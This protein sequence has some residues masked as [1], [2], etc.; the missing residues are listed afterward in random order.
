MNS[1]IFKICLVTALVLV[2]AQTFAQMQATISGTVRTPVGDGVSNV[3]LVLSD[4][5]GNQIASTTTGADGIYSFAGV[6]ESFQYSITLNKADAPLNGVSTFDQVLMI[7][8]ILGIQAISSPYYLIGADINGSQTLTT[9]DAVLV[10]RLILGLNDQ[11]PGAS[12]RFLRADYNFITPSNP[13]AEANSLTNTF[14]LNGNLSG[15]DF[16]GVKIG[17]IND[18]SIP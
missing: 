6:P 7:R 15:F 11:L 1:N 16:I 3:T 9:F 12:W 13:F 18:S 10:R 2:G 4:M 14:V 8:H 5:Q 17:D